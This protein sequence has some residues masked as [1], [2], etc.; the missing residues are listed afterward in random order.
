MKQGFFNGVGIVI[1][2]YIFL[3]G[4]IYEVIIITA[5]LFGSIPAHALY[6]DIFSGNWEL[7]SGWGLGCTDAV[8]IGEGDSGTGQGKVPGN[9]TLLNMDWSI[10]SNLAQSFNIDFGETKSFLFGTGVF[11]D[12]DGTLALDETDNLL[13]KAF[14]NLS[15]WNNFE[16]SG[17][18]G[19]TLGALNDAAQDLWITFAPITLD[20][21]STGLL[22]VD[23]SDPSWTCNPGTEGCGFGDPQTRSIWASFTL[24]R[25]PSSNDT[26]VSVPEPATWLLL[27]M[28]CLLICY[29]QVTREKVK[30]P[31]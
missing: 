21:A 3:K 6:I 16:S 29:S 26:V 24:D 25:Q 5:M 19:T 2:R 7:G 27:L 14:L 10:D 13:I 4:K 22:T 17:S 11:K 20:L 23:F 28:G 1:E 31:F 30:S 18:V 8:C 9:H 15:V 12:E